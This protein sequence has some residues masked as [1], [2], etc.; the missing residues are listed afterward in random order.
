M[1]V[2][3]ELAGRR[4]ASDAGH[5]RMPAGDRMPAVSAPAVLHVEAAIN[6]LPRNFGLILGHHFRLLHVASTAVWALGRQRHTIDVVDPRRLTTMGMRP[7]T[8]A[9]PAARFLRFG[10]RLFLLAKRRGL[11]FAFAAQLFDEPQQLLDLTFKLSNPLP[12]PSVLLAE[13]TIVGQQFV[14][15]GPPERCVVVHD[16]STPK[17]PLAAHAGRGTR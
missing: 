10:G 17:T 12:E 3:A 8:L 14:V 16:L 5:Q 2:R 13:S 4:P 6:H 15:S 9:R 7:M 11:A 1:H